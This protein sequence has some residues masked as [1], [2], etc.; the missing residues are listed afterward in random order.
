MTLRLLHPP[1]G[2]NAPIEDLE[3]LWLETSCYY[4]VF[5]ET[6]ME[7]TEWD[8]MAVEMW[9]RRDELRPYFCGSLGL[10]WAHGWGCSHAGWA[11]GEN[12]LKTAMGVDWEQGLP[13]IVV[14]G[15]KKDG[16]KRLAMWESRIRGIQLEAAREPSGRCYNLPSTEA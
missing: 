13:A 2:I 4:A 16:P 7:D 5:N 12:P 9:Q 6:V 15:I 3:R 11:E 10:P 1:L 8:Q 14:E